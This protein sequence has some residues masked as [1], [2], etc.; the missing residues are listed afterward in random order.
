MSDRSSPPRAVRRTRGG[1]TETVEFEAGQPSRITRFDG[2][3]VSVGH[4]PT[5]KKRVT[6]VALP[7]GLKLNYS[8][9]GESGPLKSVTGGPVE[10]N[11]KIDTSGD[12]SELSV[13]SRKDS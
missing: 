3:V 9:G 4:E 11:Y 13:V 1:V 5:D 2:G 7:N 8:Y 12:L 6:S 10:L